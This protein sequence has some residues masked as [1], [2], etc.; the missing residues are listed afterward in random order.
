MEKDWQEDHRE[1]RNLIVEVILRSEFR[2]NCF[3]NAKS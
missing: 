2:I 3:E 1:D